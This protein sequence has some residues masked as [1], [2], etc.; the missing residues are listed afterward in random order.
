MTVSRSLRR[1]L[2]WPAL[3]TFVLAVGCVLW[4]FGNTLTEMYH[5]WRS[6]QAS[7]RHKP[8]LSRNLRPIKPLSP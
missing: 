3:L 4:A 6:P 7:V 8:K 2:P 1:S 5:A